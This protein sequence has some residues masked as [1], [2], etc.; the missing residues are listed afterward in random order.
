MGHLKKK[1]DSDGNVQ[2]YKTRLVAKGYTQEKGIAYKKN[3][4]V[5]WKVELNMMSIGSSCEVPFRNWT[6]RCGY[7]I[8]TRGSWW[9]N[10]YGA[11][12]LIFCR[13]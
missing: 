3:G 6:I 5:S 9:K 4:F 12:K 11:T 1:K 10:V 2:K 13:K 7:F 8:L